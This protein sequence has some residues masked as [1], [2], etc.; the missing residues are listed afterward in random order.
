MTPDM[1]AMIL[2][3]LLNEAGLKCYEEPIFVVYHAGE[4]KDVM[5]DWTEERVMQTLQSFLNTNA[6]DEDKEIVRPWVMGRRP[7]LERI[8]N[9]SKSWTNAYQAQKH[10]VELT[11]T[12]GLDRRGNAAERFYVNGRRT[13][14][15]VFQTLMCDNTACPRLQ[16][17]IKSV[18]GDVVLSSKKKKPK[19]VEAP[20]LLEKMVHHEGRD[21]V[22]RQAKVIEWFECKAHGPVK[23]YRESWDLFELDG[24]FVTTIN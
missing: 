1:N 19:L 2:Q 24:R 11:R 5:G 21:L 17:L 14:A 15:R 13:S 7:D 6:T 18:H 9:Y 12:Q 22:A 3:H 8:R 10:G 16:A 20:L 23:G 4:I